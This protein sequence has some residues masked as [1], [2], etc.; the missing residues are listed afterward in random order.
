MGLTEVGEALSES[1]VILRAEQSVLGS[2]IRWPEVAAILPTLVQASDFAGPA[3]VV[4]Y[5][6]V[7]SIVAAGHEVD[8]TTLS[9]TLRAR[10]QF[11]GVGG[12]R[13]INDVTDGVITPSNV[14][15]HARIVRDAA[16]TRRVAEAARKVA[17]L[18]ASGAT[19]DAVERAASAVS[20]AAL[21]PEERGLVSMADAIG[22]VLQHLEDAAAGANVGGLR[23]GLTALD[24]QL[25]GLR[26]GQMIV[27]GA[28][29]AMG[30]SALAECFAAHIAGDELA[31]A[32][33]EGRS[34]RTLVFASLEMPSMELAARAVSAAA[35]VDLARLLTGKV[36]QGEL[37]AAF[38]HARV[39]ARLPLKVA[40]GNLRLSRIRAL[41][42]AEHARVGTL[43]VIVDYLQLVSPE[44]RSDNRERE[45]AEVSR[46]MKLL[47]TELGCPVIVLSQ[48]NRDLE[49]RKDRRPML[50]DLRESGSVEQ[51]ADVVLF[52]YRDEVYEPNSADRGIAEVIVAKQR[53]GP[54]GTVRVRF[55][56]TRTA[57][58][59]CD[60]EV[61]DDPEEPPFTPDEG[62][63]LP[64]V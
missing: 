12:F 2:A 4:V 21:A 52:L 13:F 35:S 7:R 18:A 34:P 61:A 5:E 14:E 47:A 63:G 46:G 15:A 22:Q 45:V 38:D 9:R 3:H 31:A 44:Q 25:G 51:D 55:D 8:A 39:L 32:T 48:L 37:T 19:M 60:G 59:D 30:K 23:T 17:A 26:P 10:G 49:R 41:A 29:P 54:T 28:R 40:A 53:N 50:S 16:R 11:E 6:C 43:A 36:N 57:F 24:R 33:R 20:A 42:H 56:R 64:D 1:E 58:V 27:V 62:E